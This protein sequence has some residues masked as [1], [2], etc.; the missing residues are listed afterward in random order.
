METEMGKSEDVGVMYK[1]VVEVQT[2][3]LGSMGGNVNV[4]M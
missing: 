2:E 4:V 3:V 1:E